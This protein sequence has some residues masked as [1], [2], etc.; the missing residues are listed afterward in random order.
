MSQ[1]S[2]E[3]AERHNFFG[4]TE[5]EEEE[6]SEEEKLSIPRPLLIW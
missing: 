6:K 3:K 2:P 4:K 5:E 1:G